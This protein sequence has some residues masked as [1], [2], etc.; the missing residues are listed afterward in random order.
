[1][2]PFEPQALA[3]NLANAAWLTDLSYLVYA[4]KDFIKD[5]VKNVGF[6]VKPDDFIGFDQSNESTQCAIIHNTDTLIVI[7]RGTEF[8][9]RRIRH[10][11]LD[12]IVDLNAALIKVPELNGNVH[13]GFFNK[14]EEAYD[15]VVEII[16]KIHTNQS[17]WFTGH[18][19]GGALAIITA[20]LFAHRQ[21]QTVQGV[22][23]IG[24]P[25]VGD[26]EFVE[27]YPIPLYCLINHQDPVPRIPTKEYN[28]NNPLAL[29][30]Y[31]PMGEIKYFDSDKKLQ[32]I[33]RNSA[34]THDLLNPGSTF[35]VTFLPNMLDHAPYR[36]S[37]S[38]WGK[39]T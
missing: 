7:F 29:K 2:H 8:N 26:A 14:A 25:R 20:Q 1:M 19:M 38:I 24:C 31:Q 28:L 11:I 6:T 17:I 15:D 37:Q 23:T 10:V 18:S 12:S 32:D 35:L 3:F 36:Y 22:Y 30:S 27:Q 9:P 39:L 4:D 5:K 21:Q 16:K 34:N 33:D 13:T